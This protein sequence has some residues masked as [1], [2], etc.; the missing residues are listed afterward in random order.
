MTVNYL[1]GPEGGGR[2][3]FS[4]AH[5]LEL[6]RL[7]LPSIQQRTQEITF[8]HQRHDQLVVPHLPSDPPAELL[9]SH[10]HLIPLHTH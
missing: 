5:L 1:Y 7:V 8:L 9:P 6:V 2:S 10:L 3:R 4:P